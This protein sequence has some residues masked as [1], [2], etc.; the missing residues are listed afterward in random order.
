MTNRQFSNLGGWESPQGHGSY[1][2]PDNT[3]PSPRSTCTWTE[4]DDGWW[5]TQCGEAFEFTE[6]VP[7]ENKFR[8]CPFCGNRIN[9]KPTP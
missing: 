5:Q 4:T 1:V 7:T 2:P 6:G 3:P 8:F 9:H